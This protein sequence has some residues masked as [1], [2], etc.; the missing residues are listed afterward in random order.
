[1]R[2]KIHREAWNERTFNGHVDKPYWFISFESY[3]IGLTDDGNFWSI[4]KGR[5]LTKHVK[6]T[7]QQICDECKLSIKVKNKKLYSLF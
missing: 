1:M 7:L 6:V 5:T 3:E 4:I 2:Y